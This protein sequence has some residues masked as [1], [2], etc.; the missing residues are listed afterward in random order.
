[1]TY[2][3]AIQFLQRLQMFGAKLGLE[4][5]LRLAERAGSPH[6]RLRF[7]HVAGT[8]GK[9]STCAFLESIYRAAGLR[10]G[11]YTSPHLVRFGERIQVNREL[12]PDAEVARLVELARNWTRDIP[13]TFFEVVTAMAL[14]YFEEQN[15]DLVIWETGM[16]GRLDATNIVTPLASV[17]TNI[18][19]DHQQWLGNT[20]EEIAREK[21]GIIKPG[22][23]VFT[24][25]GSAE[26]VRVAS[27]H[28]SPLTHVAPS[29]VPALPLGLRGAHQKANAALA[30]AATRVL[31]VAR[32]HIVAGLTTAYWP[33]RLQV[34]E[35]PGGQT[36][37]LDGA[38]NV[39]GMQA[40]CAEL[41]V[42]FPYELPAV[43]FGALKDKS[44]PEMLKVLAGTASRLVL[45]PLKTSRSF[46]PAEALESYPEATVC[47]SLDQAL[48]LVAEER[49][50]VVA[51][52]LY[53]VG[54]ALEAL[55]LSP[56]PSLPER[57]LN[58]WSLQRSLT[59]KP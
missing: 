8:N 29:A 37:V 53:L 4:N 15:C 58:E 55:N 20:L 59:R 30:L 1:M 17:I 34:I 35:R 6:H 25:S 31:P 44:W 16:G 2:E 21:A 28:G 54:E 11:L 23:P 51:G 12:I 22:V 43:I 27:E 46:A 7:I 48:T 14:Q 18:A 3:E 39:A 33:G 45:T 52:S 41:K 19:L 9:G 50:V 5:M 26:I 38:H 56:A 13:A 36:I 32:E 10:V 57:A 42:S 49:F 40:L 47:E 24:T